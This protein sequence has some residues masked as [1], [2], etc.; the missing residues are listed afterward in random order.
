MRGN[1]HTL[2]ASAAPFVPA[3]ARSSGVASSSATHRLPTPLS[4]AAPGAWLDAPVSADR[5]VSP[6]ASGARAQPSPLAT[7]LVSPPADDDGDAVVFDP[8]RW[9][10]GR[11]IFGALSTITTR[12]PP[13]GTPGS[14]VASRRSP[15]LSTGAA[16]TPTRFSS[17][18]LEQQ[19][20]LLYL[21]QHQL[22]TPGGG[23]ASAGGA[24]GGAS[25][26]SFFPCPT[27]TSTSVNPLASAGG[28]GGGGGN[29][30]WRN[31][32]GGYYVVPPNQSFKRSYAE[33]VCSASDRMTAGTPSVRG[34]PHLA[35]TA[36]A[37]APNRGNEE[38][39]TFTTAGQPPHHPRRWRHDDRELSR[40]RGAHEGHD[41]D[42]DGPPEGGSSIATSSLSSSLQSLD[43]AD[44]IWLEQQVATSEVAANNMQ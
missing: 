26:S 28:G 25:A 8:S 6:S 20:R 1:S 15:A 36:E 7:D 19:Q 39:V 29:G 33:S 10:G 17:E 11:G 16:P 38:D 34:M 13:Q 23:G 40:G 5:S 27:T 9:A 24:R 22:W 21:Q 35:G 4:T 41:Y 30:S 18:A 32:W 31:W 12:S 2:S 14:A 44:A 42:D 37:A 43:E 3:V